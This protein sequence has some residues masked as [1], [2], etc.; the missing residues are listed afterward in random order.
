MSSQLILNAFIMAGG[1][2]EAAWRLPESNPRASTDIEYFQSLARLAERGKLDSL[3]LA[4]IPSLTG[5][6]ARRPAEHLDPTVLLSA[7]AAVTSRIGLIGTASTTFE[8]PYNLA[9]RFGSLDQISR[10]RAG[11]NVVT[12]AAVD[13]AANFGLNELPESAERYRRADEFISVVNGL[14]DG[15]E[16]DAVVADKVAGV[17]ADPSKVHRLDHTGEF[18]R[19]A[20]PLNA[21]SL[22]QGRPVVVQAGSSDAGIALAAKYAEAVFTAQPT[23]EEGRAF[24]RRLKAET[25]SVGRNPD[26][27]KILPGIVPIIGATEEEAK[28]KERRLGELMVLD[29]ALAQLARDTGLDADSIDLD[30]PLPTRIRS[31]ADVQSS[32]YELTVNL[33]RRESLTVRE[34]LVRLGGGRG[35]RVFSGTPEQVAAT[36]T[37]WFTTGAA[38]GFNIMGAT[39]PTGLEEFVD[40]VVPILQRNGLFRTEYSGS[41]LRAHYGLALPEN[42]FTTSPDAVGFAAAS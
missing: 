5:S 39:L 19:V 12:T 14:W 22:P 17:Y 24:Y 16:R 34:L 23:V 11:W 28:A 26:G 40:H 15:W 31:F 6:P 20:G 30:A 10:G 1:H 42:T 29:H 41:T 21:G 7:L 33:A 38:D 3:F 8:E 13:A 36:I 9:R 2:H 18:F 35:H 25:A 4:D 37:E 27:V 32:R